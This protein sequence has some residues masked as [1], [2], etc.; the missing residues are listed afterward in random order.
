MHK[1]WVQEYSHFRGSNGPKHYGGL[2]RWLCTNDG[3]RNIAISRVQCGPYTVHKRWVQEYSYI[4]GSNDRN[5]TVGCPVGCAQTMGTGIWPYPGF[6]AAL[7]TVHKTI[8]GPTACNVWGRTE[9]GTWLHIILIP[10]PIV[11]S[12]K[13]IITME[14]LK[15]YKANYT[16]KNPAIFYPEIISQS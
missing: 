2:P 13:C 9:P 15:N 4:R 7:Y 8:G 1:R 3:Y 5:L 16:A 14:C 10:V 11:I 6:S 12:Q